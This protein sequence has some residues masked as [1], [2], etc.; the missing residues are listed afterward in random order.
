MP[1]TPWRS[2]PPRPAPD[3]VPS[4]AREVIHRLNIAARRLPPGSFAFVMA[5]GIV[6][7]AFRLAGWQVLSVVLLGDRRGRARRPVRRAR[8]AARGPSG[9]RGAGCRRAGAR[10]RVL[11]DRRC[12]QC[13]GHRPVH[14]CGA[15]RDHRPGG[16]QRATVA[17]A[18]L[19]GAGHLSCVRGSNPVASEVERQLVPLGGRHPVAGDGGRSDRRGRAVCLRWRMPRSRCGGSGCCST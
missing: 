1:R 12:A 8:L 5:T 2:S 15:D 18:Q 11:H 16:D 13:R 14:A 17:A 9:R 4:P 19:R 7:T 10:V 6:A 3:P